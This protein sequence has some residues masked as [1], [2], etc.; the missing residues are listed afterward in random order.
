MMTKRNAALALYSIL[1][2]S[3]AFAATRTWIGPTSGGN[4]SDAANWSPA[5]APS[6]GDAL[7]F[8]SNSSQAPMNNDLP[9]GS[10]VGSMTF[11]GGYKLDGNALVVTGDITTGFFGG[12]VINTPLTIGGPLSIAPQA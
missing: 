5:G 9:T 2:C 11:T 3:S 7:V 8:P 4:W 12:S 10:S 1:I 6:A